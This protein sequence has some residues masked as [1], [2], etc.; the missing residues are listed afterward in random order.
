MVRGQYLHS[1]GKIS[2][3]RGRLHIFPSAYILQTD[4]SGLP[5]KIS[6]LSAYLS[7]LLSTF[8]FS[9]LSEFALFSVQGCNF[10]KML[11]YVFISDQLFTFI[12]GQIPPL[13]Y[14]NVWRFWSLPSLRKERIWLRNTACSHWSSPQPSEF[15]KSWNLV[16]SCVEAPL[17]TVPGGLCCVEDWDAMTVPWVK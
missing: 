3:F 15:E 9:A 1:F 8:I 6:P 11:A 4:T 16:S 5:F 14:L 2:Q 10:I 13:F 12:V 17:K 7:L